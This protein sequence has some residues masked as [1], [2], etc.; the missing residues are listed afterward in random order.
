MNLRTRQGHFQQGAS[1]IEVLVAILLM[2][3]GMLSLGAMLS[4]SAQAPKLSGYRSSAANI[5]TNYIERIRA[6][7]DG[8]ASDSYSVAMSYDG[9]FNDISVVGC[10]FPSCTASSISTADIS[11]IQSTARHELPGGGVLM[12]CDASPCTLNSYGNLWVIWQEPST[13]AVLNPTNAD[14]CPAE[15]TNVYT[16]PAPRCLYVRFKV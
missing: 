14:N 13:L 6:N 11:T 2:S 3:F 1:L 5:A 12:K 8:F 15:V 9:T 16:N 10:T 4:F 7:P